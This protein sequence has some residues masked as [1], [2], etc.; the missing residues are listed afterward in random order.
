MYWRCRQLVVRRQRLLSNLIPQSTA[1]LNLIRRA[2]WNIAICLAKHRNGLLAYC[3]DTMA[4]KKNE[5]GFSANHD[6]ALTQNKLP[7]TPNTRTSH[8]RRQSISHSASSTT[9]N[10]QTNNRA[11][12]PRNKE[13]TTTNFLQPP[14][15]PSTQQQRQPSSSTRPSKPH[16]HPSSSQSRP[17]SLSP[18]AANTACTPAPNPK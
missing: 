13:N 8:S 2:L 5:E 11:E 4:Q 12:P 14:I 7:N 6:L 15:N 1:Y 3:C 9:S 16:T 10:P 18:Y 17:S